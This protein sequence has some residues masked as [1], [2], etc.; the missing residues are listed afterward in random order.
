MILHDFQ[1][2]AAQIKHY[3]SEVNE[4]TEKNRELVLDSAHLS[5]KLFRKHYLP[6]SAYNDYF[7]AAQIHH[8]VGSPLPASSPLFYET[9]PTFELDAPRAFNAAPVAS[10]SRNVLDLPSDSSPTRKETSLP[11][12]PGLSLDLPRKIPPP[13]KDTIPRPTWSDGTPN[14]TVPGKPVASHSPGVS[15]GK[16]GFF[17]Q[18]E[19]L[20]APGESVS[21]SG[22]VTAPSSARSVGAGPAPVIKGSREAQSYG[23]TESGPKV[24]LKTKDVQ[25]EKL[26]KETKNRDRFVD[27]ESALPTQTVPQRF[28]STASSQPGRGETLANPSSLRA[29]IPARAIGA[30]STAGCHLLSPGGSEVDTQTSRRLVT[31]ADP[32]SPSSPKHT[33]SLDSGLDTGTNVSLTSDPQR[34]VNQATSVSSVVERL[35]AAMAASAPTRTPPA[36]ARPTELL[37]M[38]ASTES[39][40]SPRAQTVGT[41]SP[42]GDS[43]DNLVRQRSPFNSSQSTQQG[44]SLQDSFHSL[45]SSPRIA[46]PGDSPRQQQRPS[47][48]RTEASESSLTASARSPRF[49]DVSAT[50]TPRSA[51][52]QVIT[53]TVGTRD[54]WADLDLDL[55]TP[56]K[57]TPKEDLITDKVLSSRLTQPR[58]DL[59]SEIKALYIPSS[60]RPMAKVFNE[61]SLLQPSTFSGPSSKTPNTATIAIDP[62]SSLSPHSSSTPKDVKAPSSTTNPGHA[63]KC[64]KS[65]PARPEVSASVKVA[66]SPSP[67]ISSTSTPTGPKSNFLLSRSK[68][69]ASIVRASYPVKQ[70]VTPVPV[71]SSHAT[72]DRSPAP[73]KVSISSPTL[74]TKTNGAMPDPLKSNYC[75]SSGQSV[76]NTFSASQRVTSLSVTEDR[77]ISVSAFSPLAVPK[78]ALPSHPVIVALA[79]QASSTKSSGTG[80]RVV[81][82][83]STKSSP[84]TSL[85][86]VR[87]DGAVGS[88][89]AAKPGLTPLRSWGTLKLVGDGTAFN[90]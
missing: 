28:S 33:S 49:R 57:S 64:P 50:S 74:Q 4:I 21:T 86:L 67:L 5:P 17:R 56:G 16:S 31:V 2:L 29:V 12:A 24:S 52:T 69:S 68:D 6:E 81:R 42:R 66:Q 35:A 20:E 45:M 34:Q 3:Q 15:Q 61:L 59:S 83:V 23:A 88:D 53:G 62:L 30:S 85:T 89:V 77:T 79:D 18:S 26:L 1:D 14:K 58:S 8:R 82:P 51:V 72:T 90:L 46:A 43:A 41:M 37:R 39:L 25:S 40:S 70:V 84:S 65:L 47:S 54:V 48:P 38:G 71:N 9:L 22:Y 78:F 76:G 11:G 87:L 19:T 55:D 13:K 63:Q 60:H 73:V 32:L 75:P 27:A 80:T 10:G 7:S 36:G 44:S